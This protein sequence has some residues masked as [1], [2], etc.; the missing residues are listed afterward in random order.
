MFYISFLDC[1]FQY[2]NKY[3]PYY[4]GIQYKLWNHSNALSLCFGV[5]WLTI[6]TLLY[7]DFYYIKKFYQYFVGD[8]VD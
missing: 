3:Y 6:D 8:L 4:S 7:M 1:I 2:F 5:C